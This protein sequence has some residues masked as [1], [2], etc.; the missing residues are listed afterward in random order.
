MPLPGL[1]FGRTYEDA[2]QSHVSPRSTPRSPFACVTC[3][4]GELR[5]EPLGLCRGPIQWDCLEQCPINVS[6]PEP[7]QGEGWGWTPRKH[8]QPRQRP[9]QETVRKSSGLNDGEQ[10][11][12]DI[13]AGPRAP[14]QVSGWGLAPECSC[15][16][17]RESGSFTSQVHQEEK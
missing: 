10:G 3:P 14:C 2:C 15:A 9:S 12:S 17:P 11:D 7:P 4:A 6:G 16:H 5:D 1:L 8:H 13:T